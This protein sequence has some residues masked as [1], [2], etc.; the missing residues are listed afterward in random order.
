MRR[1][2][3]VTLGLIVS[4]AIVLRFAALGM[5]PPHHDEGVNGWFIEQMRLT[6]GYYAYDPTNYHGPLYFDLLYAA[7]QTFGFGIEVLRV[8]GA[9]IGVLACLLPF[10]LRRRLSWP[11]A[12][13]ASALLATSPTL[14]YYARYAIHETLLGALGLAVVVAVALRR[15]V[16]ATVALA[17]MFATKETAILFVLA[18]V[19]WLL[20]EL[21][22]ARGR[23]VTWVRS[24]RAR[25]VAAALGLAAVFAA[26]WVVTFTG[27]FRAPDGV[28][29]AVGR[30]LDAFAA[31][32]ATSETASHAKPLWYYAQLGLRYEA[33][34]YALALLG[35]IAGRR[36]PLIRGTAVVGFALFGGYSL[37]GYKMP[38]LPV[39][40]LMLLAIPAA[41][42]AC[43]LAL[44][45]GPRRAKVIALAGLATVLAIT[46]RSSFV[47]PAD[48]AEALAYVHTA[49]DYADWTGRIDEL[50]AKIGPRKIRIG[51]DHPTRWPL[52]Y[53]LKLYPG[54][55]WM[56]QGDE[57]VLVVAPSRAAAVDARLKKRY[58][59][60]RYRMRAYA[61]PA[62]LYVRVDRLEGRRP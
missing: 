4:V 54:T 27:G 2:L 41:H 17:A 12:L 52:A 5:R 45:V 14:V 32:H 33:V 13:L 60:Q 15:P 61:E 62:I 48:H 55:H 50:A 40:W 16:V 34:L 26:V 36:D 20:L 8:P 9:V 24:L 46:V 28:A 3:L 39:S 25:H 10:A 44:R 49:A 38:W 51:V 42:G 11:R 30:S 47:R 57:D 29:G 53:S 21:V 18:G 7:R 23:V 43:V 31:W 1:T 6:G 19:S 35:A 56:V 59:R 58:V 22:L 37:I